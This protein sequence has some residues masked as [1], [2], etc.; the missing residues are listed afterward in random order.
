MQGFTQKR[1]E[2]YFEHKLGTPSD[3]RCW[4][5]RGGFRRRWKVR[6][7]LWPPPW[8]HRPTCEWRSFAA[9]VR[10]E[11]GFREWGLG[12]TAVRILNVLT[13]EQSVCSGVFRSTST[14][15][16]GAPHLSSS[17]TVSIQG[18]LGKFEIYLSFLIAYLLSYR[19]LKI[20]RYFWVALTWKRCTTSKFM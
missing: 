10:K 8:R 9:E 3:L 17:L 5:H 14:T 20:L 15:E 11:N 6:S 19:L 16:I 12:L 2:T 7:A 1:I 18:N 4:P 13:V